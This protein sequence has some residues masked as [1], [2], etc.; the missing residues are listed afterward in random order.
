MFWKNKSKEEEAKVCTGLSSVLCTP[1]TTRTTQ[2]LP[3]SLAETRTDFS[4]SHIDF[5]P[6]YYRSI[7][8]F[9]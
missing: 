8:H 7:S 6:L 9:N 4:L 5:F 1:H 3:I 2:G